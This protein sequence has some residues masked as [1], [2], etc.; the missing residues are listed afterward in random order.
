MT[1]YVPT[2]LLVGTIVLLI[3]ASFIP[4]KLDITNTESDRKSVV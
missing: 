1:D 4:G 3:C 2:V